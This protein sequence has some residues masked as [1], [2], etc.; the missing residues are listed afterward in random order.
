[1]NDSGIPP[2]LTNFFPKKRGPSIRRRRGFNRPHCGPHA[3]GRHRGTRCSSVR[4]CS[5]AHRTARR[6]GARVPCSC[7]VTPTLPESLRDLGED[8][9]RRRP[10]PFRR[11]SDK[12]PEGKPSP[13]DGTKLAM[14]L[15]AAIRGAGHRRHRGIGAREKQAAQARRNRGAYADGDRAIPFG[16]RADDQSVSGH[17]AARQRLTSFH[18][19]PSAGFARSSAPRGSSSVLTDTGSRVRW[20]GSHDRHPRLRRAAVSRRTSG[21]ATREPWR[22]SGPK[23]GRAAEVG[24]ARGFLPRWHGLSSPW[25]WGLGLLEKITGRKARATLTASDPARIS[26]K[27][28]AMER[29]GADERKPLP[30]VANGA[31]LGSAAISRRRSSKRS[32]SSSALT[33]GADAF[34][35]RPADYF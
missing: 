20:A 9:A 22:R 1:M 33:S 13:E 17:P 21:R 16:A 35:R 23:A 28:G 24:T 5:T 31:S 7:F 32:N 25:G 6:R 4:P 29:L 3:A 10:R 30:A 26:G 11:R 34:S 19:R 27:P 18:E 2:D 8:S 12:K 15:T 14:R